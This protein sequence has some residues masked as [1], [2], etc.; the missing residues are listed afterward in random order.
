MPRRPAVVALTSVLSLAAAAA[1]HLL[2]TPAAPVAS[3][4]YY[5]FDVN[6]VLEEAP[7][8]GASASPYWWLNS[9]G[10][11]HLDG[12]GATIQGSLPAG[13]H[14]RLLYAAR[15][16]L[17]TDNG[18]HPQNLFRLITRSRWGSARQQV[19][20]W[21]RRDNLSASPNRNGSNGLFL[22]NRYQDEDNLYYAGI[23][24]DGAAVIKKKIGGVYHT[25]AYQRV[26][27]GPAYNRASNPN[28]LPK[29]V[30]VGLTAEVLNQSDGT[31]RIRFHVNPGGDA[32]NLVFDVIDDGVRFG[33][34]LRQSGYGGLRTDFMD[35]E[36]EHYLMRSL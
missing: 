36:V 17:D 24:V 26:F 3:P 18:H 34:P 22:I 9:G 15:N 2:A 32:W 31:V 13:D 5:G 29:N 1:P 28:L 23:R 10:R 20:F 14:W 30:W 16:P 6:G 8:T 12:Q 7:S 33:P 19:Y 21:I 11:F 25:M 4:F 27:T 35:V